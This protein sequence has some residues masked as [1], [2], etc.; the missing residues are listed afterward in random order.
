VRTISW[1][2][3][4]FPEKDLCFR[5]GK[6]V[7]RRVRIIRKP[8]LRRKIARFFENR[9]P[10]LTTIVWAGNT[11]HRKNRINAAREVSIFFRR[12]SVYRPLPGQRLIC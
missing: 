9:L 1:P 10:A 12:L 11:L 5:G 8:N 3:D 4:L 2:P 6:G 7:P